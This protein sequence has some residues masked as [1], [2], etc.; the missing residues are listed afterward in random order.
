MWKSLNHLPKRFTL[1]PYRDAQGHLSLP[2]AKGKISFVRKVDFHGKVEI[3]GV[4]YFIRRELEGQ[5]VVATILTQQKKM[6]VKHEKEIIKTFS[7]PIKG[8]IINPVVVR[9]KKRT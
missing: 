2:I 6:V 7:F 9:K 4:P 8:H 5:Y 3:N 1:E